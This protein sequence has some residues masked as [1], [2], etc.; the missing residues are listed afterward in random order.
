MASFG[1]DN[2]NIIQRRVSQPSAL[3]GRNAK[4]E[5]SVSSKNKTASKS[6]ISG[7]KEVSK[8]RHFN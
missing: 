7:Y 6:D 8:G 3:I 4:R 5:I 2:E 1:E